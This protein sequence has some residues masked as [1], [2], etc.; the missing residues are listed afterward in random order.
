MTGCF[1][2]HLTHDL[3]EMSEDE[4]KV[5][6]S[7]PASTTLRHS[8]SRAGNHSFSVIRSTARSGLSDMRQSIRAV[9]YHRRAG[10]K[11]KGPAGRTRII[12]V[13]SLD[14]SLRASGNRSVHGRRSVWSSRASCM[15]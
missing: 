3:R 1:K 10:Q 15:S 6:P 7:R 4:L 12:L 5:C 2:T 13:P 14:L 11:A 9:R 8:P